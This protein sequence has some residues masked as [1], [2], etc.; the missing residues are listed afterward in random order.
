MNFVGHL[1]PTF[2]PV[3]GE[4][5][6]LLGEKIGSSKCGGCQTEKVKKNREIGNFLESIVLDFNS[7][8]G[9]NYVQSS[10]KWG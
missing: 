9:S 10:F 4:W 3:V 6:Y 1:H 2:E 7:K 8:K 5:E